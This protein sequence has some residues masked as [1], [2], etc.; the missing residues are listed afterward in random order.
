[1][2][3]RKVLILTDKFPPFSVGGAEISLHIA[4]QAIINRHQQYHIT[5]ISLNEKLQEINKYNLSG[6]DIFQVPYLSHWLPPLSSSRIIKK[7]IHNKIIR[8]LH[9]FTRALS[10]LMSDFNLNSIIERSKR[11]KLAI[12]IKRSKNTNFLPM[13]DEDIFN[14]NSAL[15][16][17]KKIAFELMPDIV[18]AD[19]FRSIL[20]AS[21]INF[22]A[23][24]VAHIRDNRFYCTLNSQ[25]MNV[26]GKICGSCHFECTKLFSGKY[27]DSLV[28]Q[29]KQDREFRKSALKKFEK[30]I[31]TSNFLHEQIKS[32]ISV[33]KIAIIRNSSEE[34]LPLV[35]SISRPAHPPEILIVGMLNTNK[36]QLE[37]IDWLEKLEANLSDFR[38]VLA[39]RGSA[40]EKEL[41]NQIKIKSQADRVTFLGH[42]SREEIY[43]A[44]AR[45]TVVA[46]PN[47]WPEPFGRVPLEAG[48]LRKPVVAYKSGGITESVIHKH[49]GL[50]VRP[51]DING[52]IDALLKIIKDPEYAAMLGENAYKHI[53]LNYAPY[54]SAENIRICWENVI[55][56]VKG[57]ANGHAQNCH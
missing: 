28:A 13:M 49:T 1:M 7:S 16:S 2:E 57:Y 47:K 20:L 38:I 6:I 29:M 15:K 32:I 9:K 55:M 46:C 25:A 44:Y 3:T 48:S 30:I 40:I 31:V 27:R 45:A 50:L 51:G 4:L 42:L 35:E 34:I 11:I 52:F 21:R 17:I 23:P 36:G 18:H 14:K 22:D 37:V 26:D 5:V 53:T 43:R 33:E 8:L 39:G 10:Y 12:W 56:S 24:V 41:K 54:S 19:N